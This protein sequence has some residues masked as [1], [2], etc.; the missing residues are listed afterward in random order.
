[1]NKGDIGYFENLKKREFMKCSM[2]WVLVLALLIIGYIVFGT[3]LNILTFMAVLGC[4]PAAK[5]TVGVV[6]KWPLKPLDEE[7][8]AQIEACS[9]NLTTSYDVVLTSTE[10]IMPIEAMVI[11]N[12][13]VYGFTT[14]EKVGPE[15]TA[16][17]MKNF[18][19]QNDCGKINVKIFHE[20]VPFISRVEGLNNIASVEKADT[21]EVEEKL[22]YIMKLYSM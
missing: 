10:K 22:K 4:L 11:S 16:H 7:R 5:A 19:L 2:Q 13:T 17:Y 14:H 12:H 15:A 20:F 8:T 9:S 18:F 1:M 21:K 3:K 6:V